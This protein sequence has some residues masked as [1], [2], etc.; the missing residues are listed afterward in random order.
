MTTALPQQVLLLELLIMSGDIAVSDNEKYEILHRTLN[1]CIDKGW[2]TASRFG[3]GFNKVSVTDA[4]RA[5]A[6]S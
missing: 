4:G 1:E 3:Q 6:I 5:K 2:V